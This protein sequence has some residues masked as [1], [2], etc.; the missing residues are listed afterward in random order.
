MSLAQLQLG[1]APALPQLNRKKWL[2]QNAVVWIS[3]YQTGCYTVK[4]YP[5]HLF[6]E[7]TH[8]GAF[9]WYVEYKHM[10]N[11]LKLTNCHYVN[12]PYIF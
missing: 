2:E 11:L 3:G 9:Y 6:A 1:L 7:N 5:N 8:Q 10:F 4:S 12:K